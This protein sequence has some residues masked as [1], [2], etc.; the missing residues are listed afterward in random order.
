MISKGHEPNV[1]TYNTLIDGLCKEGKIDKAVDILH[2]MISKGHEPNVVTYNI[3]INGLCKKGEID[4]AV[5]ILHDMISKECEPNVV[6][7]N[8]L[9]DGLCKKRD[10]DFDDWYMI[11]NR[12]EPK[13]VIYK[14]LVHGLLHEGEIEK[15][16]DVLDIM[17]SKGLEPNGQK[18]E[19]EEAKSKSLTAF[20][21]RWA[22]K[23][24]L[25]ALIQRD[26]ELWKM[27]VMLRVCYRPVKL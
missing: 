18:G 13:D 25:I 8:T 7:Y 3:L 16:A 20:L 17:I 6:T 21:E 27:I 5:D 26:E 19:I 24:D 11:S 9:I 4:K 12:H 1:V 14:I 15:A 23:E 2:D 22:V 10:I